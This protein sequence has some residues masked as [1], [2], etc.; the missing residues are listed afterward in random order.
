MINARLQ[1]T[2]RQ[3]KRYMQDF[4]SGSAHVDIGVFSMLHSV[5]IKCREFQG[6]IKEIFLI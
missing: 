6:V 1:Y 3:K 4:A 2:D 5:I